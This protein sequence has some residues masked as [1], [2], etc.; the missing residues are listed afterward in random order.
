[1][2][3]CPLLGAQPIPETPSSTWAEEWS[4]P[5]AWP[6][7]ALGPRSYS[8]WVTVPKASASA[9]L[10]WA[11]DTVPHPV[12]RTPEGSQLATRWSAGVLHGSLPL[13]PAG[14][15]SSQPPKPSCSSRGGES[16]QDPSLLPGALV[17]ALETYFKIRSRNFRQHRAG[18]DNTRLNE[19]LFLLN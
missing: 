8:S 4:P 16:S 1:M 5:L 18:R 14:L 12:S 15:D 11:T 3:V 19:A 9:G 7:P 6:G 17:P 10:A 2:G 13:L